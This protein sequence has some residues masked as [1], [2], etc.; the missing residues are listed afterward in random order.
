MPGFVRR[1]FVPPKLLQ[2]PQRQRR[3]RCMSNLT[4]SVFPRSKMQLH[5]QVPPSSLLRSSFS[6]SIRGSTDQIVC[7]N[8]SMSICSSRLSYEH[9]VAR[10]AS[11][12]KELT[13][14]HGIGSIQSNWCACPSS[15]GQARGLVWPSWVTCRTRARTGNMTLSSRYYFLVIPSC[16]NWTRLVALLNNVRCLPAS[17]AQLR[18]ARLLFKEVERSEKKVKLLISYT[19]LSCMTKRQVNLV[20]AELKVSFKYRFPFDARKWLLLFRWTSILADFTVF[21][22]FS[23]L[24]LVFSTAFLVWVWYRNNVRSYRCVPLASS[25]FIVRTYV[26]IT[27][28]I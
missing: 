24:L 17:V 27:C 16:N 26:R 21:F 10:S 7:S 6:I 14:C 18:T 11:G 1:L 20:V 19:F 15:L 5:L 25:A 13:P 3:C 12:Y 22:P 4:P 2:S 28:Y 23:I 8:L 9:I